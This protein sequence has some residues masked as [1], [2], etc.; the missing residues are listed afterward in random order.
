[1]GSLPADVRFQRS[2]D[3]VARKIAGETVLVPIRQRLGDLESI[4]T[5]NEV[6]T[7]I[8]ERLAEPITLVQ[9]AAAVEAEFAGGS[10]VIRRDM[11]DFFGQ[12]VSLQAIQAIDERPDNP[13]PI[14][15]TKHPR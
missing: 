11:E 9:I 12:L 14:P 15:P 4:Y 2:Q 5:M 6:A 13:D 3:F 7:F 8:W 1:M 10:V